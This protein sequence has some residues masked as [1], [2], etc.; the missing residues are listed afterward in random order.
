MQKTLNEHE[1]TICKNLLIMLANAL[2]LT[3]HNDHCK[4]GNCPFCERDNCFVINTNNNFV[5]CIFNC[6]KG[7]ADTLKKLAAKYP[8]FKHL[9]PL[10]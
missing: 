3:N 1:Q 8:D 10:L 2:Q 5:G 7:I 9:I 4:V 6:S